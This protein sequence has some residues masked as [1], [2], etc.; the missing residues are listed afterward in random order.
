MHPNL[1]MLTN[2]SC[3]LPNLDAP[4]ATTAPQPALSLRLNATLSSGADGAVLATNSWRA[5]LFPNLL[6]E[7]SPPNRTV[8]APHS[9][10]SLLPVGNINCQP[11]LPSI[12]FSASVTDIFVADYLDASLLEKASQ[13]RDTIC[14]PQHPDKSRR[15]TKTG[16]GR[17]QGKLPPK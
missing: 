8:Y 14:F 4:N 10:C 15:F 16:S 7:A 17:T 6:P 12:G 9:L 5:R 3:V 2:V 11:S 13:V 1:T